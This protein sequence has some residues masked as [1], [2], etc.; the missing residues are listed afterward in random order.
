MIKKKVWYRCK[1]YP[2][3]FLLLK[4]ETGIRCVRR[5]F[6]VSGKEAMAF[7][8]LLKF[9]EALQLNVKGAINEDSDWFSR[10]MP[11]SELVFTHQSGLVSMH[12]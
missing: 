5:G 3:P 11:L 12:R 10:F 1:L 7:V 9:A 6:P 2:D 4:V 8:A